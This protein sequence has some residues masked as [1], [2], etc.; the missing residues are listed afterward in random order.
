LKEVRYSVP[1]FYDPYWEVKV[2]GGEVEGKKDKER[3]DLLVS[4][5]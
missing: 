5:R 1:L 3:G 4:R 2:K